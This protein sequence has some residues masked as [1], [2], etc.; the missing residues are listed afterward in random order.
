MRWQIT[1]AFALLLLVTLAVLAAAPRAAADAFDR[2]RLAPLASSER[3]RLFT[4]ARAIDTRQ[5][6]RSYSGALRR[7]LRE[8]GFYHDGTPGTL[9][10]TFRFSPVLAWDDNI[11]GGYYHDQLDLGGLIFDADPANRARAGLVIGTRADASIRLSWAEGRVIDLRAGAELGW[12]PRHDIGRAFAQV[13]AC[14]RNHLAGWTFADVCASVSGAHRALSDSRGTAVSASLVHLVSTAGAAHELT[15]ALDRRTTAEG[16]QNGMTL[17]WSAVW[18][19]AVTEVT[20][21]AGAPIPGATATRLRLGA[22]VGWIWHD[23]P[24]SLSA[25]HLRASGGLLLGMP[26]ADQVTGIGLSVEA[27][28]GMNVELSHQVTRSTIAL[29]EDVRT[30]LSV[31]FRLGRR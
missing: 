12:S 14:A 29:F 7:T 25:W 24:V 15:L 26:R 4:L 2:A 17:G 3:L 30:G 10:R 8:Q 9:D 1:R 21:G 31:R 11:N 28:P 19:R 16:G 27:R 6:P 13:E 23:R 22:R 20:L 5:A 18:N